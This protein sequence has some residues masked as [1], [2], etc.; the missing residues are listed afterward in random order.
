[1]NKEQKINDK[2]K[3]TV[4]GSL[5]GGRP[6][7]KMKS[8]SV[9]QPWATFIA[10]GWK[11][12]EVRTWRTDHRGPLLICAAKGA[13]LPAGVTHIEEDG[14]LIPLPRGVALCLVD[15]VDCRPLVTADAAAANLEP[16]DLAGYAWAW[17]LANPRPVEPVPIR[18]KLSLFEVDGSAINPI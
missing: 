1:M 2:P 14:E 3:C 13:D 8:L 18:G 17:V 6:K 15:V 10:Q 11:T 16:E 7:E 5:R 12:I 9:R 4:R